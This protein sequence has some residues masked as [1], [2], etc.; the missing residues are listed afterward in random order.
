MAKPVA[1]RFSQVP[2]TYAFFRIICPSSLIQNN[3]ARPLAYFRVHPEISS[4]LVRPAQNT[5]NI[6]N[7]FLPIKTISVT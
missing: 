4:L 3:A 7:G 5:N 6:T 2:S 1:R